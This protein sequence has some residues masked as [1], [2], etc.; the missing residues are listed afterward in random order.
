[1]ETLIERLFANPLSISRPTTRSAAADG[2]AG[3]DG[4]SKSNSL[5][6]A[7]GLLCEDIEDL[8]LESTRLK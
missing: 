4:E 7:P 1:V 2:G 3:V 6:I 8:G 5:D